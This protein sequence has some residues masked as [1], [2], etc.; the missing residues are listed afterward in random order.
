MGDARLRVIVGPTAA[1]KSALALALAQR[2][3]ATIIGADSRQVYRGFDIGTAKPTPNEL[4]RVPHVGIDVAAPGERYSAAR[5][6]AIA[7]TAMAQ[8]AAR[9]RDVVVVGGTGFYVRALVEPLSPEPALDAGHRERLAR[10]L[11]ALATETLRRWCAALDPTRSALGRTQLLR[12][13]EVALLTGQRLSHHFRAAPRLPAMDARYL[14]LDPGAALS[15][16]IERR[17]DDMLRG[18][19]VDEVRRLAHTVPASAPAWK[20][21]GYDMLRRYVEGGLGLDL[22]TVRERLIAATRQY[23]KRQRTWFRHQLRGDMLTLDPNEP[24][25]SDRALA[26]WGEGASRP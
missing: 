8:C 9:G 12:A 7:R 15:E 14:V 4:A 20:A 23:A 19:W 26:W 17:V 1:G 3:G 16:A 25:A 13:I 2:Y 10:F 6:A 18:G 21:T 5:F 24:G 11:D 22:P